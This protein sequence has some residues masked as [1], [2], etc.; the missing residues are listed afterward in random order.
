MNKKFTLVILLVSLVVFFLSFDSSRR[1]DRYNDLY[2]SSINNFREQQ[3]ELLKT[4]EQNDIETEEGI[5]NVLAAIN[6]AR[7]SLKAFDF[8]GRYFDPV[9]YRKMNGPLPVEWETEVFE[10]FEPPYKREGT[11][12]TQA[13]IYLDEE[14][15]DKEHLK[16]LVKSAIDVSKAFEADSNTRFLKT[17][18]HFFFCNRLYLLNMAAIYTT[19]FECPDTDVVIP[20]L[21]RMM[22]TVNGIYNAYNESYNNAPLTQDYISLYNDAVTYVQAQ[23]DDFTKFDH[24]TFI[25]DYVNPLFKKNQQLL[26]KYKVFSRSLVDY[27]LNKKELSIFDKEIYHGQDPKGIFH[28]VEDEE[29]LYEIDR[30]GKLLFYDPLLSGNNQ[31]SCASCHKPTEYFTDT[32]VATA[33]HFNQADHLLRNTPSL[34]NAQYNH[35]LMLDG[36]HISMQNQ[37]LDVMNNKDEMACAKEDILEKVLS[38]KD[39]EKTF[40]KL[41]KYTPTE[42]EITFDHITSAITFYYS[43][44]S[45]GYAPFDKAMNEKMAIDA[46]V[47]HGFNV[48]MSKAQCATCHFVPQFNGV[49]PPYVGS[50]FEVL[51]VP[52]D[53]AY[54][55]LSDDIGRHGV[56]EA[57]EMKNAFRTGS[58]R[59]IAYTKP[60]MHNGVF[61]TLEEVVDFYDGGGGIGHGLAVPNQSL[62]P[63][64]LGLTKTEKADLI[65]FMTALNEDITFEAPPAALPISKNKALNTRKVGGVY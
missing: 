60:Y 3:V 10:K 37:A 14:N 2:Y 53:T 6:E 52:E 34:V 38:C 59:N 26:N 46:S 33:L 31:R 63:Y 9:S 1:T 30:V 51:G 18:D 28:R 29:V 22:A 39:Y 54:T 56:H 5:N 20:E 32:A 12:L 27:S 43:K 25:R 8:W 48:F 36:K 40:K 23:P 58:I 41:L 47:K 13:T 57:D 19:G 62:A 16:Y 7:T 11:G 55:A 17:H 15:P 50:E 64:S 65:K 61:N 24:F 42:D 49:K 4:I 45:Y 35:L 44:F 21:K